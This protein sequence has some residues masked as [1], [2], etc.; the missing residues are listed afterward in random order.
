MFTS[1]AACEI[2]NIFQAKEGEVHDYPCPVSRPDVTLDERTST[3][4]STQ[5]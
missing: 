1:H 2:D 5:V 3:W 4:E